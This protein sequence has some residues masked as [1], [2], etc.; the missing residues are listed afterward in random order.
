MEI[1]FVVDGMN[2]PVEVRVNS[3]GDVYATGGDLPGGVHLDGMSWP[4]EEE[5][6]PMPDLQHQAKMDVIAQRFQSGDL[7]LNH[8]TSADAIQAI[9]SSQTFRFSSYR[10]VNDP[11][12]EKEWHFDIYCNEDHQLPRGAA[13]HFHELARKAKA[14]VKVACFALDR[15]SY[16]KTGH[17]RDENQGWTHPRLWAQYARNHTGG[18]LIFDAK[19]LGQA[20]YRLV[21]SERKGLM[22]NAVHYNEDPIAARW[23]HRIMYEDWLEHGPQNCFERHL[24]RW[25]YNLLATKHPDWSHE[26]ELRLSYIDNDATPYSYTPIADALERIVL[27]EKLEPGSALEIIDLAS[28]LPG[29]VETVVCVW[30]NGIPFAREAKRFFQRKLETAPAK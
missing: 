26:N 19:R 3:N 2:G 24:D 16:P 30:R 28:S 7:K 1:C 12:E 29:R 25:N 10:G 9:L 21:P 5:P 8:Y 4:T 23:K 18:V 22:L 17:L 13:I 27:G 15:N 20:A 14:L 6:S 11:F